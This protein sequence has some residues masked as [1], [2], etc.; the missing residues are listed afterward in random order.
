MASWSQALRP[1]PRCNPIF[2]DARFSL[3]V[4]TGALAGQ[5]D[6]GRRIEVTVTSYPALTSRR[7][8][9]ASNRNPFELLE[10]A[11]RLFSVRHTRTCRIFYSE[12]AE[13]VIG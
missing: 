5:I 2:T 8:Q 7:Q 4:F 10:A 6:A 11:D 12:T 1:V 3:P 13:A 9:T